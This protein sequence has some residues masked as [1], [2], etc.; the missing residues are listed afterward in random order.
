MIRD[1][2]YGPAAQAE[3][4]ACDRELAERSLAEFQRQAWHVIEGK[5]SY[6][7]GWHIDAVC[8]HLEAVTRGEIHALLINMPP[9]HDKSI[10]VSVAWPCW[11]WTFS[12][13]TRWLYA[14]YFQG[15][16]TRDSL[17]CRRL[18]QSPWYQRNWGHVFQL[19]GDQNAKVRFENDK[20]GCRL[21]TSTGGVGTGEGGDRIVVDDPLSAKQAESE[22]HRQACIDW[23]DQ[24]MSTR[25]NDPKTGAHVIV[26][27]RLHENDLAGHVLEEGG[28][29]HLCLPAEYEPGVWVYTGWGPPDPRQEEGDLLWP[30]RFD[31][32]TI[33]RLKVRLGSYGTAGQLQQRPTPD[34]GGIFKKAWFGVYDR[35]EAKYER[36]ICSW[37]TAVS[38]K[39]TAAYSVGTVWGQSINHFDLLDV[40][41]KQV[42]YPELKAAVLDL[43]AKWKPVAVLVEY[44]SS[45]QQIV[46]EL[47]R[48]TRMPVIGKLVTDGGKEARAKL[49]SPLIEA[50]KVRLP[51]DAEWLAA[52]VREMTTFPNSTFADQVD[53]TTQALDYMAD[54]STLTSGRDY[55]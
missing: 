18:I 53:S 12:P 54:N 41:R 19:T 36:I 45:G 50:G 46:Q 30:E 5:H 14:A 16:S 48:G 37:D 1:R 27:Q 25:L 51:R 32:L 42:E 13:Q 52:Y 23:W 9:R 33:D 55:S 3:I 38:E 20:T 31:R 21:A 7:H 11:E 17:K 28:Y 4:D 2:K 8:E 6:V 49:V 24:S 10:C 22:A 26:M 35:P 40:Y 29:V 43:F 34:E 39:G 44:K 47:R 15:L